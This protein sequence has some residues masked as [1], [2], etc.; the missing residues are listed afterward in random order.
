MTGDGSVLA[1]DFSLVSGGM[2]FV[3]LSYNADTTS[4]GVYKMVYCVWALTSYHI[5]AQFYDI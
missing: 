5:C 4:L 2:I 1:G 3:W